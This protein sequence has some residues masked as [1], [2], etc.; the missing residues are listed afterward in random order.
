MAKEKKLFPTQEPTEEVR[1]LLRKYWFRYIPAIIIAILMFIP[2]IILID[3]YYILYQEID[4][5]YGA[6]M[7]IG[8]A[9]YALF[10][11]ALMLFIFVDYYLDVNIV[12]DRR[13]V[14]IR[15]D[16][17]FHRTISELSLDE[18]QD[19]SA[20]VNGPFATL[21]HYGDILI[22]TAGTLPNFTFSSIPHPYQVS[23]EIMD[24]HDQREKRFKKVGSGKT[25]NPSGED[26]EIIIAPDQ[27][28]AREILSGIEKDKSREGRSKTVS[29]YDYSKIDKGTEIREGESVNI[30]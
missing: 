20:S 23:K 16:G 29:Y 22:Q 15:Q 5:L 25:I 9:S 14:D 21:M 30:K 11:L 17:F 4:K 2:L 10:I 18:V 8:G 7:V 24:L 1:L 12:T 27:E 13:I 28:K 3:Y 26:V 19:V 6:I